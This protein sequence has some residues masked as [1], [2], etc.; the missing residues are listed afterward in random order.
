MRYFHSIAL[1]RYYIKVAV[2]FIE[3]Y[4]TCELSCNFNLSPYKSLSLM[5]CAFLRMNTTQR[6][7]IERVKIWIW[8]L[9]VF[10]LS[11]LMN[12]VCC[13]K[14]ARQFTKTETRFWTTQQW[15]IA[16]VC[17]LL[18]V[19]NMAEMPISYNNLGKQQRQLINMTGWSNK[20]IDWPK[21]SCR[22]REKDAE[23]NESQ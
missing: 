12:I 8:L 3:T 17:V 19:R 15:F 11:V 18:R 16:I 20:E 10:I 23:C 13:N 9:K 4:D 14:S 1:S 6:T 21:I 7:R 5:K 22:M 2:S